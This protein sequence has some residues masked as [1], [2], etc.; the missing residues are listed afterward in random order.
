MHPYIIIYN[1][2]PKYSQ[3]QPKHISVEPKI[4]KYIIYKGNILMMIEL[5]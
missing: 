4:L 5:K 1:I 3:E 2:S